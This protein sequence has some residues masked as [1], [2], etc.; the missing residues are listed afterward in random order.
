MTDYSVSLIHLFLVFHLD[1][2]SWVITLMKD[3]M[4][5]L[6]SKSSRTFRQSCPNLA[7]RLLRETW[8]GTPPTST[9]IRLRWRTALQSK[10]PFHSC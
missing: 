10:D 9:W 3:L 4:K 6:L 5:R 2:F 1:R 8:S 7:K